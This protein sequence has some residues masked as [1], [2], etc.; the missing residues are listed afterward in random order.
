[1][2]DKLVHEVV[3]IIISAT[4]VLLFGAAIQHIDRDHGKFPPITKH[5]GEIIPQAACSRY[6]LR[7]GAAMAWP[8]RI[9]MFLA[10]PVA[11]PVSKLLDYVLGGEHTSLFR[12]KQLK[13]LVNIHGKDEGFGGKLSS[14]EIQIITGEMAIICLSPSVMALHAPPSSCNELHTHLPGALDLTTKTAF[15]AMT[16]IEKVFML[17]TNQNLDDSTVDEIMSSKPFS[18]LP[19]YRGD[20]KKEI[21]G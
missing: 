1:M 2:L 7:I 15:H 10:F 14:D 5:A 3:A 11:W 12:R 17:S 6:G 20:N 9:L 16:P 18:R 8:V 13:A 21:V 19:I 4:A